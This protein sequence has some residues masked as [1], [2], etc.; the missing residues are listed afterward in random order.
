MNVWKF[1]FQTFGKKKKAVHYRRPTGVSFAFRLPPQD[2]CSAL[3]GLS[4]RSVLGQVPP[5]ERESQLPFTS[6]LLHRLAEFSAYRRRD[7]RNPGSLAHH[8]PPSNP[9][10]KHANLRAGL[11]GSSL[12]TDDDGPHSAATFHEL[13]TRSTKRTDSRHR[14]ATS[15]ILLVAEVGRLGT[16]P[17]LGGGQYP[18]NKWK[19]HMAS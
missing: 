6:P 15:C 14:L 5:Q 12:A 9:R 19:L 7:Y 1:D 13:G 10:C 3:S 8:W 11:S 17:F 2:S 4:S 16:L 18:N